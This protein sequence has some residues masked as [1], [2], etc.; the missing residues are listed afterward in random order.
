[1][2]VFPIFLRFV[3]KSGSNNLAVCFSKSLLHVL[4]LFYQMC[5][6]MLKGALCVRDNLSDSLV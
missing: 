3:K 5:V 6:H 1:M 4:L 2:R